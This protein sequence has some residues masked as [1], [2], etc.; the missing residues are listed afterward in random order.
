MN[1]IADFPGI[2]ITTASSIARWTASRVALISISAKPQY[3]EEEYGVKRGW[4]HSTWKDAVDSA[5]WAQ[6]KRLVLFHHD[7]MHDDD[8]LDRVVASCRT[9]MREQGMTFECSAGADYQ[10]VSI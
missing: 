7:P 2:T 6:A 3:T 1:R 5:H 8:F 9:Y 4:G 10:Q